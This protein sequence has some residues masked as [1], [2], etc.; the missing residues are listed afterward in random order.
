MPFPRRFVDAAIKSK[1]PLQVQE[2]FTD[3]RGTLYGVL[4]SVTLL[5]NR[6]TL[7]RNI[8]CSF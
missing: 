6:A 3:W 1:T 4:G 8:R 2:E 7:D 5:L